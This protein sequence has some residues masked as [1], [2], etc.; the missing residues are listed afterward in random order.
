VGISFIF[1]AHVYNIEFALPFLIF[2]PYFTQSFKKTYGKDET[3]K[4]CKEDLNYG[5]EDINMVNTS[6][7]EYIRALQEADSGNYEYL[8][9]FMFP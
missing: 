6:R 1:L 5:D 7:T 3:T 2:L 9:R 8:K 4:K